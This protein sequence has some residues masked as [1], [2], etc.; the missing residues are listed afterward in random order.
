[1]K[2]ELY[3]K[4]VDLYAGQDLP[5]EL[6]DQLEFAAFGDADLSHDMTTLRKTVD[7]LRSDRGVEFTEESFQ[8]I[9]MKLYTNGA[10]IETKAPTPT[11]FQYH[12]PMQG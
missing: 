4:L 7:M 8:R 12:L 11:H 3:K 10:N 6:E 2:D 1:L 5:S 9:L